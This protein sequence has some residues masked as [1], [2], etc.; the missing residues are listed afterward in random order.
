VLQID[1]V[2]AKGLVR[3]LTSGW[4]YPTGPDGRVRRDEPVKDH[5]HSD[6]GDAFCYLVGGVHPLKA[7]PT[8]PEGTRYANTRWDRFQPEATRRAMSALS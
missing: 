4:H 2:Q 5:P 3:A 1:P 8:L 7:M 6:H